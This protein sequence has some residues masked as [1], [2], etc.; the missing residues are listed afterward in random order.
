MKTNLFSISFFIL[1]Y[2]IGYV[3]GWTAGFDKCSKDTQEILDE[4]IEKYRK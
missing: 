2:L 4:Y 1:G 3:R